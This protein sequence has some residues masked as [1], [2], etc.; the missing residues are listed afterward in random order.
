MSRR[1][2][3]TLSFLLAGCC[4]SAQIRTGADVVEKTDTIRA[5][6][7]TADKLAMKHNSTQTGLIRL[8]SRKI[9]QGFAVFGAPDLIKI[10]QQL[11]GVASGTELMS[12]MYVHGGDGSDNLF[13][14]DGVPLY[15]VTHLAGLFSAFNTDM[16]DELDFYK[17]GFPARYGGRL[18]SVVDIRTKDGDFEHYHGHLSIGLIDGHAQVEGPIIKGRTS[19]NV[20]LRRTWMDVLSSPAIAYANAK[21][22]SRAKQYPDHLK[23]KYDGHYEMRD[24]NVKIT[25][26]LTDKDRLT[27]NFYNGRDGLRLGYK[28][29]DRYCIYEGGGDR[30]I[31]D[32]EWHIIG[33]RKVMETHYGED[34]LGGKIIWG[35]V[36]GSLNWRSELSG[37]LSSDVSVFYTQSRSRIYVGMTEWDWNG[38]DEYTIVDDENIS[39]INDIG[40]N[41][42]FL[43][44]PH[45]AH[46][47]RFG[48]N[49]QNHAYL[50]SRK[51]GIKETYAGKAII[52]TS[53][54]QGLA[55]SGFEASLYAEDEMSITDRLK[56]NVGLRYSL[57]SS[58]GK[59]YGIAEPRAALKFQLTDGVSLKASYAEMSQF[60]HLVACT[61]IDLPT[62]CW[63]PSTASVAPMTSRQVAG[64]VYSYITPEVKLNVEGWYKTMD[65]LLE[66]SGNN[67]IFPALTSWEKDF[68]EGRG[69]SYGAEVELTYDT[70]KTS[71]AAYYTLSWSQRMF[72]DFYFDWYNDRNDNR[73]KLTLMGSYKFAKWFEAY[74]AWNY[75]TGNRVTFPSHYIIED[76][77]IKGDVY[78]APYNTKLPDYHRLDL[79]LNFKKTT[80][81]GNERTWNLSIYNVYC[82]MNPI[83]GYLDWDDKGNYFGTYVGIIPIIPTFSYSYKF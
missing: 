58:P 39:R 52:D 44:R 74:A 46:D 34:D 76:G 51:Y 60:S 81:R 19:F 10:L 7:V 82:R 2:L 53:V 66:Y 35:N 71:L 27:L 69:R 47:I 67:M 23:E 55:F 42:D 3:L 56:A 14:L 77:E 40:A 83:M 70:E 9:N 61:Y 31:Y 8:D 59:T 38:A 43:W 15:Q 64:G 26:R 50:P 13:L 18:S 41:A 20:G 4:L 6:R 63:M 33:E 49:V 68:S 11:P 75:H 30:Y 12:G 29:E 16:I 22:E 73:H 78:D 25:H 5:S 79:G 37:E 48:G 24:F 36:T 62:N 65:H 57:Y 45:K 17:S 80:K 32:D 28:E 54:T 21:E 72:E 1:L